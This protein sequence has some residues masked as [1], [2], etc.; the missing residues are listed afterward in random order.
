MQQIKCIF[1]ITKQ[2]PYQTPKI[3]KETHSKKEKNLRP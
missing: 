1:K 3:R 2:T